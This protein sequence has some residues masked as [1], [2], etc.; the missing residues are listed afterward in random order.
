MR[1]PNGVCVATAGAGA[2]TPAPQCAQRQAKARWR[3][4]IGLDRRYL[5]FIIFADQFHVGVGATQTRRI[6]RNELVCGRGSH[7]DCRPA[8]RLCAHGR[9][10]APPGTG[11]SRVSL[12]VGGRRLRR[13]PRRF[14]RSLKLDHQPQLQLV[15]AQALQISAIH[16][17]MDSRDWGQEPKN[18]S[19][20]LLSNSARPG[21]IR[22]AA[23]ADSLKPP[24]ALPQGD[25]D[26]QQN[27]FND[28]RSVVPGS[29]K[30]VQSAIW[31]AA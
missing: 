9:A 14:V 23:F 26:L 25:Y 3:N 5:D 29:M 2:L 4:D 27:L 12:S 30:A 18:A 20:S 28:A 11:V 19:D 16:A 8:R 6:A 1:G 22:D 21:Q 17:H 15:L 10:F 13:S 24:S 7:R 31:S